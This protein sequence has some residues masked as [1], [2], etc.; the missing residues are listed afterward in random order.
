MRKQREQLMPTNPEATLQPD[1]IRRTASLL[2]RQNPQILPAWTSQSLQGIFDEV[3]Q[4]LQSGPNQFGG[5]KFVTAIT[6][7]PQQ[8]EVLKTLVTEA[9]GPSTWKGFENMLEVMDAQGKRQAAGSLTAANVEM[10]SA[11][12]EGGLGAAAK[13]PFRPSLMATA[14]ENWRYGRN[15]AQLADLLTDPDS[16][17]M[18]QRL[19]KTNPNT[20]KAQ[21]IVDTIAGGAIGGKPVENE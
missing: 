5:A 21:A 16:V 14:Y 17:K 13:I 9:S 7:N 1:D 4:N 6:G 18:I 2:R 11:L 12:K 10:Q 19:A 8:K 20:A 3:A 15:T